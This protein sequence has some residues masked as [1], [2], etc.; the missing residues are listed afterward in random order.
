MENTSLQIKKKNKFA[1]VMKYKNN[2]VT[3]IIVND[4]E[5]FT[6]VHICAHISTN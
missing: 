5:V 3:N 1:L 2:Y 4:F 6:L